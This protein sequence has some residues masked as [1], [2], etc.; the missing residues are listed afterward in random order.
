MFNS[1]LP[2]QSTNFLLTYLFIYLTTAERDVER[3]VIK[4][5][6]MIYGEYEKKRLTAV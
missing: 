5:M 3:E 1:R 6:W 4:H 2:T